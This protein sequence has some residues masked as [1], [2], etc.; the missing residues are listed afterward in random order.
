MQTHIYT[1]TYTHLYT[2]TYTH[3]F[4]HTQTQ[5][6]PVGWGRRIH[7]LHLC[8]GVRTPTQRVS[9]IRHETLWWWGSSNAGALGN[10]EYSFVAT[11]PRS[12]WPG[13]V[14]PDS[15][16]TMRQIEPNCGFMLN[17]VVWNGTVFDI[18]TVL[19]LNRLFEIE[20]FW[21]LTVCKQKLYL[22]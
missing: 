8:K 16:V 13:V 12:L 21:H 4:A 9:W 14:A 7:Q 19:A 17:W 22:Y 3:I 6:C 10:A 20:L 1:Y 11:A 2:Y 15:V 18:E 5:T